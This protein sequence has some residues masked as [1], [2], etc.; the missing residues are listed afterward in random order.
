MANPEGRQEATTI[1]LALALGVMV[2]RNWPKIK[3]SLK[4]FFNTMEK[5]YGNL[6]LSTLGTLSRGKE[7]FEDMLAKSRVTQK[8][9]RK[10]SR[11]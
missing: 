3:K 5:Q 9:G 10:A 2:G 7:V 6:S 4:P 11:K 8:A 1:I